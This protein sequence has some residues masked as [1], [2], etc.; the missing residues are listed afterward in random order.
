MPFYLVLDKPEPGFDSCFESSLFDN[1]SADLE[2][3]ERQLN[4]KS[5]FEFFRTPP[6]DV[7]VE[8][9]TPWFDAQEGIDWL[10]VVIAHI[11]CNPS[12]V[13]HSARLADRLKT[14]QDILRQAK[15]IGA[16]WHFEMDQ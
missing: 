5:H 16:R 8:Q 1:A 3:V 11:R 13:Q 4:I 7:Y 6:N 2:E 14:C 10:E 9:E 15:E 12:S